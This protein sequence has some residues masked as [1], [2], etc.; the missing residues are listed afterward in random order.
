MRTGYAFAVRQEALNP[1]GDASSG[2]GL[3]PE[4]TRKPTVP[5]GARVLRGSRP[6]ETSRA[7]DREFRRP[8]ARAGI[9]R[10]DDVSIWSRLAQGRRASPVRHAGV[11]GTYDGCEPRLQAAPGPYRMTGAHDTRCLDLR[12]STRAFEGGLR[13]LCA[14]R[15]ERTGGGIG[16][17][18]RWLLTR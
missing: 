4:D 13:G 16:M 10:A 1:S 17:N 2:K 11:T 8:V 18:S 5:C 7:R 14:D 9:E 3:L 6:A 12:R 15:K